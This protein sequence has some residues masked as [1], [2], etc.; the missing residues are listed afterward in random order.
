[1]TAQGGRELPD[2]KRLQRIARRICLA[3]A[4]VGMLYLFLRFSIVRLPGNVV[5]WPYK[6]SPAQIVDEWPS[7]GR[8]IE[9]HDLVMYQFP[10]E[11]E[12]R[13]V[14]VAGRAGQSLRV[15]E[16]K[17][18]DG[19]TTLALRVGS[20]VWPH[21]PGPRLDGV[22]EIPAGELLLFN[23]DEAASFPDS[24][25]YGTMPAD[26]VQSRIVWYWPTDPPKKKE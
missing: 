5:K 16:I 1:V 24:R 10:G 25:T 9:P 17:G 8:P 23:H 18:T 11:T 4:G 21:G 6:G 7:W 26:G 2:P 14:V 20:E 22:S 15:V 13:P 12:P 19:Q 3:F